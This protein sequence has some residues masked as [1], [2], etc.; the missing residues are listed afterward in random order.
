MKSMQANEVVKPSRKKKGTQGRVYFYQY[1][2][3]L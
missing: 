3:Y 1:L 2:L